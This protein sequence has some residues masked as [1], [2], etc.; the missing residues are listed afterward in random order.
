MAWY[1][2]A[3]IAVTAVSAVMSAKAQ[4]EQGE[5]TEELAEYNAEIKEQEA[6][7]ELARRQ[8]EA[9]QFEDRG[10]RFQ[11]EQVAKI[12]KG[13]VLMSGTP[14]ILLEETAQA[15]ED[16]RAAILR[17]GYL[18]QSFRQ[19]EAAGM[20]FQGKAA[21]KY[22]RNASRATLLSGAGSALSM[23]AGLSSGSSYNKDM[24]LSQKHG[25]S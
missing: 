9:K 16:D 21:A 5:A 24:A 8:E 25:I 10:K 12:A 15:L 14:A 2:V 1:N 6:A 17:E 3:V 4:K 23:G 19:S 20:R 7:A 11:G 22:G 18:A 13:G